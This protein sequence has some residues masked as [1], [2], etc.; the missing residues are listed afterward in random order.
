MTE[1]H[2][3]HIFIATLQLQELLQIMSRSVSSPSCRSN[4]RLQVPFFIPDYNALQNSAGLWV[5]KI[6]LWTPFAEVLSDLGQA[7]KD[8]VCYSP[9]SQIGQP[10]HSGGL[11]DSVLINEHF[12]STENSIKFCANAC[13]SKFLLGV[14]L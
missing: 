5:E 7:H 6:P 3:R 2:C 9:V 8:V 10:W 13:H 14:V 1:S 4:Q 12:A 11:G